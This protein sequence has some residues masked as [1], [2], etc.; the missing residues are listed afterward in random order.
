MTD[1]QDPGCKAK[2]ETKERTREPE[3]EQIKRIPIAE[4]NIRKR[5]DQ[6]QASTR[7]KGKLNQNN[8]QQYIDQDERKYIDCCVCDYT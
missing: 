8:E 2:Q 7:R 1:R 3:L 5:R 6:K 4:S